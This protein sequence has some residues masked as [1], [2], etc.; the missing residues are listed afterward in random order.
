MAAY[1]L[2]GMLQSDYKYFILDQQ[3]AFYFDSVARFRAMSSQR[4]IE[5]I[6]SVAGIGY[7]NGHLT[8]DPNLAEGMQATA[9]YRV[10]GD[11]G[12]L[13][14]DPRVS[15]P[16]GSFESVDANG[17]FTGWSFY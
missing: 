1:K 3:P 9:Y 2:N 16:N 15:L 7:S 5:I 8:H 14:H 13:L 6:P 4:K 12:R 17:R 10:E 11:S